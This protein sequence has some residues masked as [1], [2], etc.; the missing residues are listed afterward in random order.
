[1]WPSILC[2]SKRGGMSAISVL[3]RQR[4]ECR[5][6]GGGL[7]YEVSKTQETQSLESLFLWQPRGWV[8]TGISLRNGRL[9]EQDSCMGGTTQQGLS[10]LTPDVG[11][12]LAMAPFT[13]I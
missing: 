6:C 11:S 12:C 9:I 5:D 1:M 8:C 3:R 4:G 10:E 13:D 7:S 2:P